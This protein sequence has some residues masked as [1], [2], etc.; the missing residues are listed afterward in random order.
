MNKVQVKHRMPEWMREYLRKEAQE[1][2]VSFS[3]EIIQRLS[4]SIISDKNAN[5]VLQ[6][7]A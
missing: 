7:V 2:G 1:K 4:D 5:R 3:G 6:K